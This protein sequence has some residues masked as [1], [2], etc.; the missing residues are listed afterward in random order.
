MFKALS[1]KEQA[2]TS[3]E[4]GRENPEGGVP[5]GAFLEDVMRKGESLPQKVPKTG[6]SVSSCIAH[7]PRT[8]TM[9]GIKVTVK[10]RQAAP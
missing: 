4:A 3:T 8:S 6:N 7:P 9:R 1:V 2:K 10:A 5:L